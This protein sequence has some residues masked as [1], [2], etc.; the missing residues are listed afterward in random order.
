MN[1]PEFKTEELIDVLEPFQQEL[2]KSLLLNHT[3][4]E[5]MQIW[6]NV[7]G[8]DHTTSFGGNG[9][10]D[11]LKLFKEEFD[12][13]ILG[14]NKYKDA[15]NEFNKH[16]TVSKFFVVSFISNA[17]SESLGVAAGV[18][19]PLIVLALGTIGRIGLNAY[20]HSISKT[21]TDAENDKNS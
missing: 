12:K 19:A 3:E 11:Y 8:P 2:V 6:I 13:F 17:L 5:A 15:I 1:I 7:T 21:V 20:R 10:G 16:A 9:K 4:E 18:V 14:E